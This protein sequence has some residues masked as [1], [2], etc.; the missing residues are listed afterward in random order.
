MKLS[1]PM[2]R[3]KKL[4]GDIWFHVPIKSSTWT[5]LEERGLLYRD[6]STYSVDGYERSI[7]WIGIDEAMLDTY[8]AEKGGA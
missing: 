4:L 8:L 3:A 2:Q 7:Y 6:V 5:A 1:E